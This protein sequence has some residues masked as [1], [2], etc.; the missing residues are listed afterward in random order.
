MS[1]V[2]LNQ[3]TKSVVID[4]EIF[5]STVFD[6]FHNLSAKDYDQSL[7]KALVLGAYALQLDELGQMLDAAAR[8]VNGGLMQL[9]VLF[10][11]RGLKER[12]AAVGV[13]AELDI[14]DVLQGLADRLGWGDAISAV[15]EKIGALPKRKVGDVLATVSGQI[16]HRIVIEA[17]WEK[18]YQLGDAA[19]EYKSAKNAERTAFGQNY[20]ALANR[21]AKVSIFVADIAGASKTLNGAGRLSFHPENLTFVCLVDR[22]RGDWSALETAYSIARDLCLASE[23][24]EIEATGVQLVAKQCSRIL[25]ELAAFDGSLSKMSSAAQT[26]LDEVASIAETRSAVAARLSRAQSALER[27]LE[28]PATN[29]ELMQRYFDEV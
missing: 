4:G 22:R 10:E 11:L 18:N 19:A 25:D 28:A 3:Q 20:L 16:D 29:V 24:Q 5:D 23:Y 1:A 27:W 14:T 17:K 12:S 21:D 7:S 26:I 9:K 15:G 6:Y 13:E 8:D 2:R